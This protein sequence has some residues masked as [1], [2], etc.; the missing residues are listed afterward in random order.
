MTW[1]LLYAGTHIRNPGVFTPL[2]AAQREVGEKYR[3]P[4][5]IAMGADDP[6]FNPKVM[7]PRI[8]EWLANACSIERVDIKNAHHFVSEA[9]P[10]AVAAAIGSFL[11]KHADV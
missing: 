9:Q 11:H 6:L 3:G 5:L 10:E 7:V 8:Q 1:P 2:L 4:V